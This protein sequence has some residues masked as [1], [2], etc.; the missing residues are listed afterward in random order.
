MR[1]REIAA[2]TIA[3]VGFVAFLASA[4]LECGQPVCSSFRAVAGGAWGDLV[5]HAAAISAV[6]AATALI[7]NVISLRKTHLSNSAKMVLDL[8]GRF[9]A[10]EMRALRK[11]FSVRLLDTETPLDLIIEETAVLDFLEDIGH[12]TK[13]DVLDEEMVRMAFGWY[14]GGYYLAVTS[15]KDWLAE[16]RQKDPLF[17]GELEWLERK[18]R[19][20]YQQ[21]WRLRG[22]GESESRAAF[23]DSESRLATGS[24]S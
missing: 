21:R 8:Y 1:P 12:Q 13:R 9:D 16:A 3:V 6:A 14:V 19:P 15:P 7:L 22:L 23:L 4:T 17:Y 11:A 5:N 20:Y 18:T 24:N 2:W 10:K